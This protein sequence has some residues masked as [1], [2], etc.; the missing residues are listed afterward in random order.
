M[1]IQNVWYLISLVFA[2][3]SLE[4]LVEESYEV[5]YE[6]RKEVE[7]FKYF[8]FVKLVDLFLNQTE[9]DQTARLAC[10]IKPV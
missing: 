3:L 1:K 8:A 7:P 9:I 4:T 5:V 2:F 10:Q 6:K